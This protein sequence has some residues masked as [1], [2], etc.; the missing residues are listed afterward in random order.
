MKFRLAA[1]LFGSLLVCAT[2]CGGGDD[3]DDGGTGDGGDSL[4]EEPPEC[5]GQEIIPL[6]GQQ[7]MVISSIAIGEAADGLDLDGDDEPDNQ[8]AP[9]AAVFQDAIASAFAAFDFVVPVEFFDFDSPAA[10]ECVKLAVYLGAFKIDGDGDGGQT[11]TPEGDCNDQDSTVHRG[12]A[13]VADNF[14]DDDCDGLADEVDDTPSQDVE[15]RDGDG[16]TIADGDCDDTRPEVN[17]GEEVCGD[18]L[19]N[20]CDGSADWALA[21]EGGPFCTPYDVDTPD[22]L[23]LDPASFADDGAP[24]TAFRSGR[25]I[26]EGGALVLEVGPTILTLPIPVA[27]GVDLDLRITGARI[28]A[29]LVMT[30]AGWGMTGGRLGGVIDAASADEIRG[31]AVDAIQLDP[32]RSLLDAVF[33]SELAVS[34]DLPRATGTDWPDCYTPDVDVDQDGREIFCDSNPDDAID[35]VDTCVDGDGTVVMDQGSGASAVHCTTAVDRE[36]KPRFVDGVSIELNFE[37]VPAEFVGSAGVIAA[38]Q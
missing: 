30:P 16:V 5:E 14:R 17:R 1:A 35:A 7:H 20:D 29:E 11:A 4:F 18:G 25:A 21:D 37:S 15:D 22:T 10:D 31:V 33:A 24:R 2:A 32:D 23:E 13:E 12:V 26:E 34:L 19:D 36:G 38:G 8:L 9:L 6:E 28:R 27:E 3:D